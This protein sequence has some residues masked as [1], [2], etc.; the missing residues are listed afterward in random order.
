MWIQMSAEIIIQPCVSIHE[1]GG[2]DNWAFL[3]K[4]F[5]KIEERINK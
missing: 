5:L 2:K 1:E 3:N 4:S